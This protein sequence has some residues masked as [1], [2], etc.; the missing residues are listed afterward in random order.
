MQILETKENKK[1]K[2]N[3]LNGKKRRV[4][5]RGECEMKG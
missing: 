4:K 1:V 2:N 3:E 5:E